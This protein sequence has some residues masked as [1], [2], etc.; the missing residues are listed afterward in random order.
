MYRNVV[1]IGSDIVWVSYSLRSIPRSTMT[2][3]H[4]KYSFI[5]FIYLFECDLDVQLSRAISDFAYFM[6]YS[7]ILFLL[8]RLVLLLINENMQTLDVQSGETVSIL[9][10]LLSHFSL[11]HPYRSRRA[12]MRYLSVVLTSINMHFC[13]TTVVVD[14]TRKT[15]GHHRL[16]NTHTVKK[17][18]EDAAMHTR[19]IR[20]F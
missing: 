10:F 19:I 18:T 17:G 9:F 16:W 15:G 11:N 12:Y 5:L 2:T 1:I 8:L 14:E 4:W 13:S 7:K 3:T 6:F 20:Y